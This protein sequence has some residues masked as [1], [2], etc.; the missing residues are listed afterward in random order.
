MSSPLRSS[1][2]RAAAG[3]AMILGA[4]IILVFLL[5]SASDKRNRQARAA[6][7]A[8]EERDRQARE[9]EALQTL[10]ER[11]RE[12]RS[13][14]ETALAGL[15]SEGGGS[16][17]WDLSRTLHDLAALHGIRLQNVKYG[18]ASREG[19]KGTDLEALDVEFVALGLYPALKPFMLDLEK[20][21][22]PF[23]LSTAKLEETPEG[24]RLTVSLR[25]FRRTGKVI[26]EENV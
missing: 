14:M 9:L 8:A 23:G 13:R 4:T 5:P 10:S 21:P 12:A 3:G 17:T 11:L 2:L 25:L 22:I 6:R 24:A 7:Q 19:T 20:S 26:A 18:Q 16:L 1:V 15:P